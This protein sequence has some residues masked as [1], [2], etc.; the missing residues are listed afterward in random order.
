MDPETRPNFV[1]LDEITADFVSTSL[2]RFGK[3]SKRKNPNRNKN[4]RDTLIHE[5]T[6]TPAEFDMNE[7]VSPNQK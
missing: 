2:N 7:I 5:K 3:F 6:R 1:L 4:E